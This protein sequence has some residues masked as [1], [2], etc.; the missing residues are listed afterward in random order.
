[1]WRCGGLAPNRLLV[2]NTKVVQVQ[3]L[4]NTNKAFVA[5]IKHSK[6]LLET[7]KLFVV[8]S[9]PQ[10]VTNRRRVACL[11]PVQLHALRTTSEGN[12]S[13]A[14]RPVPEFELIACRSKTWKP[15][16]QRGRR[17]TTVSST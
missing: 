17:R 15:E 14:E 10:H 2:G 13:A 5:R 8:K 16:S 7:A 11:R 9:L 3:A 12:K 4:T 1:M 6:S